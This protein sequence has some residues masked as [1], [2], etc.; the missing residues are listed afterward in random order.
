MTYYLVNDNTDAIIEA[1]PDRPSRA[2]LLKDAKFFN[3]P[4]YLIEGQRVGDT[5]SPPAA[6]A[7]VEYVERV[8]GLDEVMQEGDQVYQ[9]GEYAFD[10][11]DWDGDTV[12]SHFRETYMNWS[13]TRREPVTPAPADD[14][15]QVRF[16]NGDVEY[17]E[18]G[19]AVSDGEEM[20][21]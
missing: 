10:I 19:A 17:N 7:P 11:N 1:Y 8:L 4:V 3:C 18:P 5:V 21:F 13:V 6:P 15:M 12:E 9:D 14:S 2:E 16:V 20:E